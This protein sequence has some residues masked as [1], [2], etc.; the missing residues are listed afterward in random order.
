MTTRALT[1]L[2]KSDVLDGLFA[3]WDSI[4]ALLDG[5]PEA[6]WRAAT[7][8]P[9][10]DVQGV[11][12]HIIGTESFLQGIAAPEPDIDVKALAHVRNDIGAMN[13]CWVRELDTQS[14]SSVLQRYRAITGDRRKVLQEM[15][16]QDWNAETFTP[17]GPESYG[18]FMRIRVFDCWMHEQDI[19]VAIQRPSSDA[20]LA[21]AATRLSLDEVAATLG[22]VVGKLAKA[23][24]GSRILFDLT[25][26]LARRIRVNVDG[27]AA[28]VADFGGLEPTATVRM[29]ALQ[30]TRLAGGR[31]MCPARPQDVELGDDKDVAGRIV[32]RLNFVI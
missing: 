16:E 3:V 8:L 22:F 14:S 26:P 12:S 5:L 10:W 20:E 24:D 6:D 30:F 11:V 29:D 1:T 15:S 13:E 31:P 21:G 7:P 2:D 23:P 32:E 17:A 25:G 4:D 9:G 18:R 28:V 27:R 19:R